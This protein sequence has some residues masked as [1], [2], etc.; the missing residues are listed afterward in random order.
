MV[1]WQKKRLLQSWQTSH[2]IP[3]SFVVPSRWPQVP[4]VEQ[5][6]LNDV[7]WKPNVQTHFPVRMCDDP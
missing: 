5:A 6:W 3:E 4:V 1:G 2:C 7:L